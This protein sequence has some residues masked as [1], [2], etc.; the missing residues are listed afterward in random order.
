MDCEL[1]LMKKK[2]LILISVACII[3]IFYGI[4][5]YGTEFYYKKPRYNIG[6]RN[7]TSIVFRNLSTKYFPGGEESSGILVPGQL[8]RIMDPRWPVPE[9]IVVTF[10]EDQ[11]SQHKLTVITGLPKDFHGE[12]TVIITKTNNTFA[13]KLDANAEKD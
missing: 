13:A 5:I 8:E 2:L 4:W 9:K 12:I 3:G 11:G 1:L 10:D 7:D 6:T